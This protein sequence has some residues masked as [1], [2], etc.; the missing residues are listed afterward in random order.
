ML[1]LVKADT[2]L[3]RDLAKCVRTNV[4]QKMFFSF[5]QITSHLYSKAEKERKNVS[6]VRNHTDRVVSFL[7]R[8]LKR[9]KMLRFVPKAVRTQS[10]GFIHSACRFR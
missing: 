10:I 7:I 4:P 1:L 9:K 6:E 8:L 3:G 5:V 2:W